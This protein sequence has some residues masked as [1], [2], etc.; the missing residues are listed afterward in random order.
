MTKRFSLFRRITACVVLV[1][2]LFTSFLPS[3]L[4]AQQLGAGMPVASDLPAPGAMVALSAAGEDIVLN[5]LRVDSTDPFRFQFIVDRRP[6]AVTS[7]SYEM[8]IGKNIRYFLSTLV[9]PETSVWVNLSPYE[10]DRMLDPSVRET[11]LGEG[12]VSQ[13]YLLKELVSSLIHPDTDLGRRFWDKVYRD[14]GEKYGTTEIPV[15]TFNK[16]WIVADHATVYEDQGT[17]F[18]KE[19]RLKVLTDVDYQAYKAGS[20]AEESGRQGAALPSLAATEAL[21]EVIIPV[22]EKEVNTGA[23]FTNLRQ[24]FRGFILASWY[25]KALKDSLLGKYYADRSL[26]AGVGAFDALVAEKVYSRYIEAFRSGVFNMIREDQVAGEIVPRKYFS[27]GVGLKDQAQ[28]IAMPASFFPT[29]QAVVDAEVSPVS[30]HSDEGDGFGGDQAQVA[31]LSNTGS[32]QEQ[33]SLDFLGVSGDLKSRA[34]LVGQEIRQELVTDQDR[35][36]LPAID[37]VGIKTVADV[38]SGRLPLG[39]ALDAKEKTIY[40]SSDYLARIRS[41]GDLAGNRFVLRKAYAVLRGGSREGI[42]SVYGHASSGLQHEYEQVVSTFEDF[43]RNMVVSDDLSRGEEFYRSWAG[44]VTGIEPGKI[45]IVMPSDELKAGMGRLQQDF[46]R[47]LYDIEENR[48]DGLTRAS[49]E[50]FEITPEELGEYSSI[51]LVAT[52]LAPPT[53][54]HKLLQTALSAYFGTDVSVIDVTALDTRK[55]S[56]QWTYKVRKALAA[57]TLEPLKAF[58][59]MFKVEEAELKGYNGEPMS[60]KLLK[61]FREAGRILLKYVYQAGSDHAGVAGL[62]GVRDLM[63]MVTY[64][65]AE[66]FRDGIAPIEENPEAYQ[67]LIAAIL[68][69]AGPSFN[70]APETGD[71]QEGAPLPA[72]E[73]YLQEHPGSLAATIAGQRSLLVE[74]S[75]VSAYYLEPDEIEEILNELAQDS[76]LSRNILADIAAELKLSYE[77][78]REAVGRMQKML[79][80][81]QERKLRLALENALTRQLD[82]RDLLVLGRININFITDEF[83]RQIAGRISSGLAVSDMEYRRFNRN[84]L[85]AYFGVAGRSLAYSYVGRPKMFWTEREIRNHARKIGNEAGLQSTLDQHEKR[86]QTVNLILETPAHELADTLRAWKG[87]KSIDLPYLD[88][89]G[90]LYMLQRSNPQTQIVFAHTVRPDALR[91]DILRDYIIGNKLLHVA[92]VPLAEVPVAAT[93]TRHAMLRR[94]LGNT[95]IV[96]SSELGGFREGTPWSV[97]NTRGVWAIIAEGFVTLKDQWLATGQDTVGSFIAEGETINQQALQRA[98]ERGTV[99]IDVGLLASAGDLQTAAAVLSDADAA[100]TILAGA[101]QNVPAPFALLWEGSFA[102]QVAEIDR[103]F[104]DRYS[105]GIEAFQT[106]PVVEGE[107]FDAGKTRVVFYEEGREVGHLDFH[108]EFGFDARGDVKEILRVTGYEMKKVVE[109]RIGSKD[110]VQSLVLEGFQ[111]AIADAG[112]MEAKGGVDLGNS[113]FRM[114]VESK[115]KVS[116]AVD[117]GMEQVL[118]GDDFAGL[119]F[120]ILGISTLGAQPLLTALDIAGR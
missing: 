107:K 96:A 7:R 119:D 48:L 77:D 97:A 111:G 63:G 40:L 103:T 47:M 56:V 108:V 39:F 116:V 14:L 94:L 22:L 4:A 99:T 72:L 54:V 9:F 53:V 82:S 12:L 16:V 45:R 10:R 117:A 85:R 18:I 105:I 1:S 51:A 92:S 100:K 17:A 30:R 32:I 29:G 71:L 81:A 114:N 106:P 79:N 59:K 104:E 35:Q 83:S 70:I 73:K 37:Q 102:A 15:E 13:D 61:R 58:V 25:K 115:G 33:S 28:Y 112:M 27:G 87:D 67:D 38:D 5:G 110:A 90:L 66:Q 57:M 75:G 43:S 69:L 24:I 118:A 91:A 49:A 89:V 42:G 95:G 78:A 8:E 120:K 113:D 55:K 98:Q 62:K 64:E 41:G 93:W 80:T 31:A 3:N 109:E 11:V 60:F 68:V 20:S 52:K 26:T 2:F 76:G 74:Q 36:V 44:E 6:E 84:A 88:T 65:T 34:A 19:A 21:R 50:K 46:Q 23:N 101:E 86:R